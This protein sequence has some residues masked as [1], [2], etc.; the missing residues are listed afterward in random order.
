M[1]FFRCVDILTEP[2]DGHG[3]VIGKLVVKEIKE[4]QTIDYEA[5]EI[6]HL[7]IR[8]TDSGQLEG[9]NYTEG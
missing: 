1:L 2:G 4:N 3:K 5:F 6:I 7:S 9:I 8:L